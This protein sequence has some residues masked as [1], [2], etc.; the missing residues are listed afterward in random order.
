MEMKNKLQKH[1]K[2]YSYF[3][4]RNFGIAFLSVIG[5][6]AVVSVPTYIS[7]TIS[8]KSITEAE[9][10]VEEKVDE[11]EPVETLEEEVSE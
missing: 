8:N 1:H 9:T 11:K 4:A 5:L 7:I 6:F 10:Q 3:V 2:K